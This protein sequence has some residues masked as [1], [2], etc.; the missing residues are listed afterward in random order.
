[1]A[2]NEKGGTFELVSRGL[3]LE[4][5]DDESCLPPKKY[6]TLNQLNVN[7]AG[8]KDKLFIARDVTHVIYLEQVK[9][10]K[11]QMSNISTKIMK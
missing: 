9:Y 11:L 5:E 10:T 7:I 6:I 2:K 4:T 8:V 1:M 3:N